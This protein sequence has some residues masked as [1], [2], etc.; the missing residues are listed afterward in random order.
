M[1]GVHESYLYKLHRQRHETGDLSPLPHG[2]GA[3]QARRRG[4]ERF[5]KLI[6]AQ[7]DA[8][9]EELQQHL[10]QKAKREVSITTV[11][12]GKTKDD[13]KIKTRFPNETGPAKRAAFR[14]KQPQLTAK[15]LVTIGSF[16]INTTMVRSHVQAPKVERAKVTEP[17][18][19]KTK[20]S[21]ISAMSQRGIEATM[22]IEGSVAGEIFN[23]V[24]ENFL[25]PR[26]K[27]REVVT[28]DNAPFHHN[29][30]AL[31]LITT[32]GAQV[33]HLPPCRPD[34]TPIEHCISKIKG[35]LHSAKARTRRKHERR[36]AEVIGQVTPIDSKD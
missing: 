17:F 15:S 11:W 32:T 36:L 5:K 25:V 23:L 1:F 26:L 2:G 30:T 27:S 3:P 10:K 33:E 4:F 34:C 7:P 21:V 24:V 18:E 8:L 28:M 12:R 14:K 22:K 20:F 19:I 9:L 29:K 6:E 35:A 13:R 31:G 16:S